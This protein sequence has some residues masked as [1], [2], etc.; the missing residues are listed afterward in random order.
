LLQAVSFDNRCNVFTKLLPAFSFN[1]LESNIKSKEMT[2]SR[3]LSSVLSAVLLLAA[4]ISTTA[5]VPRSACLTSKNFDNTL[6]MSAVADKPATGSTEKTVVRYVYKR[7]N[8]IFISVLCL[9]NLLF[10][11]VVFHDCPITATFEIWQ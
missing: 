2:V 8:L 7:R 1:S 3:R 11:F 4:A 6:F 5:F 9:N 10:L